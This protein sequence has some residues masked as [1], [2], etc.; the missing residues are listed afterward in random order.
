M[1][2]AAQFGGKV[3]LLVV[4]EEAEGGWVSMATAASIETCVEEII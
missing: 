4:E 2:C 3:S 1:L